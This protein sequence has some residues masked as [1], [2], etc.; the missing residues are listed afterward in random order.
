MLTRRQAV[1][2]L[3]SAIV[4]LLWAAPLA[5]AGG[6]AECPPNLPDCQIDAGGG[7]KPPGGKP[8]GGDGDTGGGDSGGGAK[9][10]IDDAEVPCHR[11]GLGWF[12]PADR[13]YWALLE[14]QPP[15]DDPAWTIATHLPA[16][17]KPGQGALYNTTCTAKGAEL[18][19]GTAYSATPPP[20]QG[21][22]VDPAVLA[23]QAIKNMRLTGADIG[24]AP[25]Q[26][27]QSLVGLPVWLWNNPTATT[28]GPKVESVSAG[29]VTVTATAHV[30]RI[31]WTTGDGDSVTCKGPGKAYLPEYGTQKPEC[32]HIYSRAGQYAINA[33]SKWV[34]DWTASTGQNGRISTDRA[35]ATNVSLAEAQA[36][37]TQ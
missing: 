5:H 24:I 28:W 33:T 37:N 21:G 12:N 20:G 29:G 18:M 35:S 30:D 16:D 11:P 25:K 13:C 34:V 26:G 4:L 6:G 22:M 17:W 8:P 2:P 1:G 36:L 3:A 27:G 9:C 14:P 31:I 19:G 32:G 23:Q 10:I 15:A 7:G